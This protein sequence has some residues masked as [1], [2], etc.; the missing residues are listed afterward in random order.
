MNSTC[1]PQDRVVAELSVTPYGATT[2]GTE[3]F[4]FA[5]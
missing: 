4:N 2:F 3:T 5:V 1:T